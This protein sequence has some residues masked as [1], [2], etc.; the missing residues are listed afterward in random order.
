M[1]EN[2]LCFLGIGIDI[3]QRVNAE[4]ELKISERNLA[5]YNRELNLLNT[6][7]DVILRNGDVLELYREVCDCIVRTG[8]YKLAW[9]CH[10]PDENDA[11]QIVKPLVAAGVMDYLS[12]VTIDL[13]DPE[14]SKGPTGT[15]LRTGKTFV[16]NDVNNLVFFAPWVER[17]KK[18]SILSS[19]SLYLDLGNGKTGGLMI[20]SGQT[21]A[22]DMHQVSILERLAANLSIAVQNIGNRSILIE[23]ENRFRSAFEDSAIGMG[24]TSTEKDSMGRWLKGK[25]VDYARCWVTLNRNCSR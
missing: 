1:N 19:I 9:I 13:S 10:K 20:Y 12:D 24:L 23:S 14:L 3:S 5:E 25:P 18:H 21:N 4:E 22:F 7:N 6:I 17:A 8:G 16:N 11:D 2:Q 15:V